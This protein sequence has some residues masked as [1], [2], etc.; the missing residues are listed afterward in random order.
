[1]QEKEQLTIN[2]KKLSSTAQTPSYATV[3]AAGFD[4]SSNEDVQILPNQRKA[5]ST[6]ICMEIPNG[7][8]L[9]VR[10]RSG[11]AFK[12]GITA[13]NG[14]VDSDYRGE[15]KVLLFNQSSDIFLCSKGDRIAQGI[16]NKI[17]TV[18]FEEV[19]QL[20]ETIRNISGFG[21]TGK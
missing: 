20:K 10:G 7:Y 16:I 9:Q 4:I 21:S 13:F 17:E 2:I 18:W 5:I 3:G 8:E 6:G 19:E 15:I 1:M 12:H 11:L 14:T